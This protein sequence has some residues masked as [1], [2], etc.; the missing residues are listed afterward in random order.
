MYLPVYA[1]VLVGLLTAGGITYAAAQSNG[2]QGM[3]WGQHV[4]I[5]KGTEVDFS[6]S[7]T[8]G[9]VLLPKG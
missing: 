3:Q 8:I 4:K 1:A 2:H 5:G 7:H 6:Q 9:D